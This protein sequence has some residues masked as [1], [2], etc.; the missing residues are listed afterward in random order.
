M[1]F[2]VNQTD[3]I[4]VYSDAARIWLQLR[5]D[6]PTAEN[7]GKASFKTALSLTPTQAIALAGEL[8][9]AA[10]QQPHHGPAPGQPASPPVHPGR[11]PAAA[12][13]P[14]RPASLPRKA[15]SSPNGAAKPAPPSNSPPKPAKKEPPAL[16]PTIRPTNGLFPDA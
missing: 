16:G 13:S 5:R 2:S 7:I 9:R 4:H 10:T 6:V 11:T 12:A 1:T 3:A 14:A 15:T 8:L